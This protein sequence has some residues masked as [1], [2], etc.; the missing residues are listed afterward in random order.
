MSDVKEV[1]TK[2]Q[3][4]KIALYGLGTET[5][6]FLS[7]FGDRIKVVG[8]LDGFREDGEVYGY[9]VI[10]VEET[11]LR[12]V[13]LILVVARPGS[14]KAIV[15]KIGTF[16]REKDIA[17]YDVRG[18]NLLENK[19]ISYDFQYLT[20]NTLQELLDGIG[21]ADVVSF[22][23]FDTLVARR[24]LSYTDIFELMDLQ[25]QEKGIIIPDFARLRLF[26]EKELSKGNAPGLEQ[27]YAFVLKEAGGAFVTASELAEMEWEIDFSVMTA[28]KSVCEVFRKAVSNGKQVIVTTDS[29]YSLGQ[30]KEI[31]RRFGLKDYDKAL[32]SCEYGI[33]K[34]QG[35]FQVVQDKY[36]IRKILHI[37]D[38]EVSDIE[39]ALANGIES[40][41]VFSGA[42]LF[43]ALGGLGIESNIVTIADRL[44]AG[45]FIS[46]L[47][48]SPFWFENG[49]CALSVADAFEIGYLFCAPVITDFIL[50]M[51]ESAQV[52]DFKQI[53]FC[54]RDGYLVGRLFRKVAPKLK[55]VYFLSSRIA[56][57]RA[58]ME[59][60]EDIAYVDSMKYSGTQGEALKIRFGI[61]AD[62]WKDK[63][64]NEKILIKAAI[65][66]DNYKKYINKLN[67]QD[68]KIAMFDF[69]AKGTMQM[70]LQKLFPQHVRGFYFLQLEPEFMADKGLDIQPFYSNKEKNTSIIFEHY[71]ILETILTSPYPQIEELDGNGNPVFASETRS[72]KDICCFEKAQKGIMTYFDEYLNI[73]PE[74]ARKGNKKLD[75]LFLSLIN[76]VQIRDADF[77]DLK[78]EDSFFGRM[79]DMKDV[80]E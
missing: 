45:M 43:D 1:L 18:R 57:I 64:Q 31:L 37:G 3:N 67:I 20:G 59:K 26:A 30:I 39:R 35:L 42:D 11:S 68:S 77:L 24:V 6:R 33:S 70:Y 17:L 56:A 48:N 14:C 66:R 76:K 61:T 32:V 50:W 22:D 52:Q 60:E 44:K 15:K 5:K 16:C 58:G 34:T 9:P 49:D 73:L 10:P 40:Y 27:I 36:K 12:G 7:E 69:V 62:D 65:Q 38:D 74:K 78:V 13:R 71:Y 54:A 75:E 47:F 72:E 41:R 53:L 55:S 21:R 2:Y 79:T 4:E 51:K 63:E 25:L 46:R 29:Y 19:T 80:I 8:L 23:L 28:R